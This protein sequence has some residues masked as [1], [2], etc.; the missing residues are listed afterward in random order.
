VLT[1]IVSITGRFICRANS[2]CDNNDNSRAVTV[3]ITGY[4]YIV[5]AAIVTIMKITWRSIGSV[6]SYCDNNG[7]V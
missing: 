5:L 1:V 6:D 3:T 4:I 7:E 2:Y